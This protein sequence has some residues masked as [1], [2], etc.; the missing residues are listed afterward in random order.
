MHTTHNANNEQLY[1]AQCEQQT[2]SNNAC[3]KRAEEREHDHDDEREDHEQA[4][5]HVIQHE[6]RTM[7]I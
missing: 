4:H 6:K 7:I 3:H 5:N 2:W 1:K